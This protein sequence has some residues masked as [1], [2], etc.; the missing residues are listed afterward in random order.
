MMTLYTCYHVWTTDKLKWRMTM[1]KFFRKTEGFTLV[2]LIVVIAILGILAGVGTVGYSGYVK[3]ANMAADQQLVSQV[4][5]ALELQY[6]NVPGYVGVGAVAITET[7]IKADADSF[8]SAAMAA[9]FGENWRTAGKLQ[10]NKWPGGATA[11]AT[12]L[13]HF[14]TSVANGSAT[15][16]VYNGTIEASFED[17]IEELF[18]K[19][20]EVATGVFSGSAAGA[21]AVNKAAATTITSMTNQATAEKA[22]ATVFSESWAAKS[23]LS[24]TISSGDNTLDNVANAAATKARNAAVAGFIRDELIKQNTDGTM[25]NEDI[26]T[27]YNTIFNLVETPGRPHPKDVVNAWSAV[28]SEL[29][30]STS[31]GGRKLEQAYSKYFSDDGPAK[32]DGLA[33]YAMMETVNVVEQDA[34]D[35]ENYWASMSDAIDTY[36]AIARDEIDL[37]SIA[38]AYDL[39]NGETGAAIFVLLTA[40]DGGYTVDTNPTGVFS[41]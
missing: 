15:A 39:L 32:N 7:G 31:I 8:G 3:K 25:S 27:V 19:M 1:K 11:T 17:D 33:Y 18:V 34:E 40:K 41:E 26:N 21:D 28:K 38:G 23:G 12:V 36:A 37:D 10:Y 4:A 13:D 9:A 14:A 24:G 29:M 2:E 20:E 6:Y 16:D 22:A 30:S 5:S 35:P